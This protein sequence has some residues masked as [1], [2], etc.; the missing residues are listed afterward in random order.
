MQS[1]LLNQGE[2]AR[3]LR[4]SERTLERLRVIGGGP[5]FVKAGRSVRYRQSD[6]EAWI[7]QRVVGST[8]EAVS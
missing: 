2:A 3:L 4:L 7:A 8:S 5:Q 6:I 1:H